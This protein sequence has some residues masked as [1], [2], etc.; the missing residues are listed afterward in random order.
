M[1]KTAKVILSGGAAFGLAHIGAL[2][3]IESRF[4]ISGL[5]GTSMGAIIGGL[6]AKGYSPRE[7]LHLVMEIKKKNL[8]NPLNLDR[9]LTG[10]FD[11]KM[12]L[13]KFEEWTDSAL[14]AECRIPFLAVSYDLI[15][16]NSVIIDKGSLAKAMRASASIPYLFSPYSWGSYSLVDGGIEY[17][18]PL[19]LSK[20]LPGDLTIAVNVLPSKIK[21]PEHIDIFSKDSKKDK[22][23][24]HEVFLNSITQNQ[25]YMAMHSIIDNKPDIVIDAWY[26]K[27]NVFDFDE[28][29]TFYKWG[30]AKTEEIL[31]KYEQPNYIEIIRDKYKTLVTRLS[32]GF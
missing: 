3:V 25:A 2:Q 14:I 9:N 29:E 22:L 17:P 12:I 21:E 8:F 27:G 16:N 26:P 4:H 20:S 11:G 15:K 30:I 18:L 24:L 31:L 13:N 7:I 32:K 23:W 10:I 28:T 1:K 5:I 6:Y 19:G